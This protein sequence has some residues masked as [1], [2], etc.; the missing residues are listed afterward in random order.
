MSLGSPRVHRRATGSTNDDARAL[1]RDGA[2]HGALVTAGEQTAGRGRRGRSWSAVPGD[3]LLMSIVLR[4]VPELLTLRV[5][6][7]VARACGDD[8]QIKWP[9]DVLLDGRKVAGI[10]CEGTAGQSW[11]IAGIG[12][13]TGAPPPDHPEA[14]G[15]GRDGGAIEPL[16]TAV[17][18]ELES[19]LSLDERGVVEQIAARDALAG[20]RIDWDGGVGTATGVDPRGRLL[21][22]GDDGTQFALDAGEVSLAPRS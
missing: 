10:L 8:T 20:C 22:D 21:V 12:V 9:N 5:A 3:A 13:N 1:A 17:L 4:D 15:L 6:I 11:A 19:A 16:L 14:G 2:P 7:A 18:A